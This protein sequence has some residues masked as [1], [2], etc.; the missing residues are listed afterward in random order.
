MVDRAREVAPLAAYARRLGILHVAFDLEL[1]TRHARRDFAA[2]LRWFAVPKELAQC[3]SRGC[4]R[5]R[6]GHRHSG[7]QSVR[8][9]GAD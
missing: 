2:D 1:T 9:N 4:R 7:R 8:C 5:R 3:Q 6:R